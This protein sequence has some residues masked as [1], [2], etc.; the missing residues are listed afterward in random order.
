M[1]QYISLSAILGWG[2]A[3]VYPTFLAMVAECT[4]PQDR[5]KSIGV[6]RLWRDLGYAI[7]AILTGIIA[8][9]FNLNAAIVFIAVLTF[10]SALIILFRMKGV[11]REKAS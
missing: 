11:Q 6:F 4:H 1:V 2:T 5:A 10:L 9:M 7:G 8:D 3:M